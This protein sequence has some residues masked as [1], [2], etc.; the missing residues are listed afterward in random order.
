MVEM[1]CAVG[2]LKLQLRIARSQRLRHT[3]WSIKPQDN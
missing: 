3:N 1:L 2:N